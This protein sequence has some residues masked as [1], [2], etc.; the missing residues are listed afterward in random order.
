MTGR[1]FVD[2]HC[3]TRASFD[4]LSAPKA[5]VRAAAERG[6]THL[7]ITDH[8]RIE[9][10]LEAREA[11]HALHAGLEQLPA[12]RRQ[13]LQRYLAGDSLAEIATQMVITEALVRQH[14]H[15]GLRRLQQLSLLG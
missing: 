2:L 14:K 11:Q 9:G 3:H 1:A 10:A 13:V 6:L 5:V 12:P 15:R 4:C 8:D 7:A